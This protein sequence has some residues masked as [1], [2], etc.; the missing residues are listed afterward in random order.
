MKT[1][2]NVGFVTTVS[3]RWP[4][5]LPNQRRVKYEKWL[6]ENCEHNVVAF[7]KIVDDG[8]SLQGAV[9]CFKAN[10]V[11]IIVMLYGAFSGDDFATGLAENVNVPIVLW[12]LPEPQLNGGRLLANALVAI[13]MNSASLK[14]LQL[15]SY[16]VI[17]D[18]ND[19]RTVSRLNNILTAYSVKKK[20]SKVNFGLLGYRPTAFY[21]STF[22]EGLIRRTFG[23]KMEETDLKVIFDKMA[24]CSDEQIQQEIDKIQIKVSPNLPEGHLENHAR[25]AIALR[26]TV[27]EKEYDYSTIKCWPEMG[28][29]HATPCA[30]MGRLAD[31]GIHVLCE[32]DVDA[33]LAYVVSNIL[34][35]EPCF[36]TDLINIREDLNAVTVW[37]CG[38]AAPSLISKDCTPEIANHPLAGQGTAIR[39]ILKSG[40]VTIARFC[41][42][43]GKYKL[44]VARG[45]AIPS[46]MYTP[47]AMVNIKVNTNVRDF[48][49]KIIDEA[50]P[51]HYS[52]VWADIA[53][54]LIAYAK[55]LNLEIIE[56]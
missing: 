16:A 1:K 43:D 30:V 18:E 44:F 13:T 33:G 51:H 7:E 39:C 32:G 55:L 21:N 2:L 56:M 37:H 24:E 14:R 5:E 46:D 52:V 3:G 49:Y 6:K 25:L 47:G 29:L 11:D 48:A 12:A 34:T 36:I 31:E 22:D 28:N 4:R 41:N 40:K 8:N 9:D 54:E 20:V 42:I 50:I 26:E 19:P 35:G 15:T 45:E 23:I 38:N 10:N 17:G 53:D 27:A